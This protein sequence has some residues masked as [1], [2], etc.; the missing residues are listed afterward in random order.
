MSLR[1]ALDRLDRL[2]DWERSN[3][4]TMRTDL[5]SSLD[6]LER[7]GHPQRAFRSVH[8]TGTKGKGTVCALIEA[9]LA[10]AGWRVGRYASPHLQAINERIQIGLRP[11]QDAAL[12]AALWDVLDARDTAQQ[13]DSA[14]ARATWFDV[15][16]AAA[17]LCFA[18]AGLDWVAVEVGLGGRLDSTNVIG[19]DATV[20][21]NIGLEHTEVLGDT[22][23]QIA[24]EKAGIIKAGIPLV[25]P[26]AAESVAGRVV[27]EIASS[28][29]SPV[30]L[31]RVAADATIG[32]R[33]V[34]TARAVLDVLGERGVMS[35]SFSARMS[36][37][38]LSDALAGEVRLPGRMERF[39]VRGPAGSPVSV[40]L[41]GAHVGF[42]V[43]EVLR[44]LGL[45][46]GLWG[47][48]VVLLALGADKDVEAVAAALAG[49]VS[50]VIC[51]QTSAVR[52]GL[53]ADVLAAALANEGIQAKVVRDPLDGFMRCCA[54][55]DGHWV[56]VIG[57]L[58]LAG[59]I[60]AQLVAS[61][62]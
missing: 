37:A 12:S 11:I 47:P 6:L 21:T 31:V 50:S 38:D 9:G 23:E 20:I 54:M 8:V 5:A 16:T 26:L 29:G 53:D 39:E 40:V 17:Y 15:V 33:N 24:T 55:S 44:E 35:R 30:R 58:Y 4:T 61:N 34:A 10:A 3:R 18:R 52:P 19:P 41:D 48:P 56:L 27:R 57:S 36:A 59:A 13:G 25:T 51:T 42:A 62:R 43:A 46:P 1:R 32:E 49:R 7:L 2:P 22:I 45:Q 60:R 28:L 14:A